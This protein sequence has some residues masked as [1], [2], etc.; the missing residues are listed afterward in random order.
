MTSA[1]MT[2]TCVPLVTKPP[3]VTV[4][5]VVTFELTGFGDTRVIHGAEPDAAAGGA[6]AASVMMGAV[7]A[8]VSAVRRRTV[9]I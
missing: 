7:H 5:I 3:P 6:A 9:M 8:A 1:I 4:T 2:D